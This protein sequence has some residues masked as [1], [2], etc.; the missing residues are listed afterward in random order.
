MIKSIAI[1]D[2]PSALDVISIHAAKV[3]ELELCGCF[4]DPFKALEYLRNNRIDL[5][6]LDIN[7]PG[8]SGMELIGQLKCPPRIVFTTAYSQYALDSYEFEAIDYLLKPIEFDRFYRSVQRYQKQSANGNGVPRPAKPP[9]LFVKD[10]YKQVKLL[11]EEITHIQS[12]GNYL[13][14]YNGSGRTVT[15]MTVSQMTELLPEEMFIRVHN[16]WL[17]NIGHIDKIEN[18]HIHISEASIP[19]GEKYREGFYRRIGTTDD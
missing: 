2:E 15:R 4:T 14:I 3:P 10:G 13:N 12:E 11:F 18:N 17:V 7:M 19:I 9:H 6:F 1:D 8:L 16:S 5:V